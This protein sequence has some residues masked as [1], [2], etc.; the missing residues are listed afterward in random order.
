MANQ[1]VNL[2]DYIPGSN[3]FTWAHLLRYNAIYKYRREITETTASIPINVYS[4]L[5]T[6]TKLV[7]D[8]LQARFPDKFGL[9]SGRRSPE[10]NANTE[11]AA[12]TS[13]H[14]TGEGVD[15]TTIY[16]LDSDPSITNRDIF[17][18]IQQNLPFRTLIWETTD[19]RGTSFP[20][21]NPNWVHIDY[22]EGE[23]YQNVFQL[24]NHSRVTSQNQPPDP[25]DPVTPPEGISTTS[26]ISQTI[27]GDGEEEEIIVPSYTETFK[28]IGVN[29]SNIEMD[30]V[31]VSWGKR[32]NSR[33]ES[34]WITLKQF[35]IHLS[36]RYMPQGLLP[37]VELIP[38]IRLEDD[39]ETSGPVPAEVEETTGD[40][41]SE[42]K[43]KLKE[44]NKKLDNQL[45]EG[46]FNINSARANKNAE[47]SNKAASLSDLTT[48]DPFFE[49]HDS[50]Y[51]L[52]EGGTQLVNSRKMGVRAFGQLVLSPGATDGVASK[53]GPIGFQNFEMQTGAQCD[54]GIALIS[55]ELVD[56][57]GN[58]FT[59]LASPWSFIYNARYGAVAG[60]YWFRYG[61]M[62]RLPVY[63]VKDSTSVRFWTHPGWALFGD[64]VRKFIMNQILPHKPFITLTQA[65]NAQK[66][67]T[68]DSRG[69][70]LGD[71]NFYAMFDDG[72]EY[73]EE[74]GEVAVSRSNLT[75]SNYVK[76]A[77][78]NP[79]LN[80]DDHGALTASLSF[81]TTGSIVHSMPLVFAKVTRFII[82][83]GDYEFVTLGDLL[84][85][86]LSDLAGYQSLLDTD[87]ERGKRNYV[88][89]SQQYLQMAKDRNF[90]GIVHIIGLGSGKG[91]SENS[92]HPDSVKIDISSSRLDELNSMV[93][94]NEMSI[95]RWFRGVLDDNGCALQSAATGSGAGINS[96]WIIAVT[97]T[98]D[99]EMYS[100]DRFVTPVKKE[101]TNPDATFGKDQ[102]S[103]TLYLMQKEKDVFGFRFQGALQS[104][105]KI[106]KSESPNAMKLDVDFTVGDFMTN[107]SEKHGVEQPPV[108]TAD[109]Q[110]GLKI[111]FAQMQNIKVTALCHPWVGPGKNIFIKGMGFFDGEYMVLS[112][113]HKLDNNNNFT[114][115][116]EGARMITNENADKEKEDLYSNA[117]EEGGGINKS[118]KTKTQEE[119][120]YDIS[121]NN[122]N[123]SQEIKY[124]FAEKEEAWLKRE[125]KGEVWWILNA[126]LEDKIKYLQITEE[127]RIK[128][129]KRAKYR[130]LQN[131]G[132]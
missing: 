52:N 70:I 62:L 47:A 91:M 41:T 26:D 128:L 114:T 67:S 69:K 2:A 116:F 130:E 108:T 106:E 93:P 50:M 8:P 23:V 101:K 113:T 5:I 38:S 118:N 119:S 92:V 81:R 117:L 61:W 104:N 109:R 43:R 35:L 16:A 59:D 3:H 86:Y 19:I 77:I 90:D 125:S 15:I 127:D 103:E 132:Y 66:S 129:E 123:N 78:L 22:R 102:F 33:E 18:W 24:H 51:N 49:T 10:Y 6:L 94:D 110:R 9:S 55:M 97:D 100:S 1:T 107:R 76:L 83:N 85:A 28:Q 32:A 84:I 89:A 105:I 20:E 131:R 95:I 44:K 122:E 79:S 96:A 56:I 4:N 7:L 42:Y 75:E 74:T 63:N 87:T 14:I 13:L 37:F 112:A 29:I 58:K 68:R 111:L 48:I 82:S 27:K 71:D 34:D 40:K 65:L 64:E 60:D 126:T 121:I 25:S 36:I 54:N 53:P 98:F 72:I 17:Y 39:Y 88:T 31:D 80:V 124:T 12:K 11:G 120:E 46:N 57:Q 21:G 115:E 30:E 99:Q 45:G 73:D